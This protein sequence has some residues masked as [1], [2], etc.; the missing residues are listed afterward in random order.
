MEKGNLY[1]I[2]KLNP[3]DAKEVYNLL[4]RSF[5][6]DEPL[7][8][9][10]TPPKFE[11]ILALKALSQGYSLKAVDNQGNIVGVIINI[12]SSKFQ[13][14]KE[15]PSTERLE[16]IFALMDHVDQHTNK[17][18]GLLDIHIMT[19]DSAWRKK[20]LGSQ[21]CEQT[22]KLAKENGF[23]GL[24]ALCTGAYSRMIAETKGFKC[25]YSLNYKDYLDNNG[26][27]IFDPKAPHTQVSACV[28]LFDNKC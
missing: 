1:S 17:P 23:C 25:I 10:S 7:S 18:P 8:S 2:Q 3:E 13:K 5:F 22:E 14:F 16:K 6:K 11:D 28:K 4:L 15:V 9:D 21:F 26:K 12:D 19:V 24:Y 20:G 27:Q